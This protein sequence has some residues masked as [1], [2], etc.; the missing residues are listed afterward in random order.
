MPWCVIVSTAAST[1]LAPN[2]V[3]FA[4][5]R[6]AG[7][8]T[9]Q[10]M[11][12]RRCPLAYLASHAMVSECVCWL[13]RPCRLR[14]AEAHLHGSFLLSQLLLLPLLLLRGGRL[15]LWRGAC[16]QF[17]GVGCGV[18][19][20]ACLGPP[21]FVLSYRPLQARSFTLGENCREIVTRFC[22]RVSISSRDL[23]P[24]GVFFCMLQRQGPWPR[25]PSGSG[26]L[27]F[28]PCCGYLGLFPR[29]PTCTVL[30]GLFVNLASWPP[31][32]AK[33]SA[34]SPHPAA[35][36]LSLQFPAPP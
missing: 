16:P 32:L 33:V 22:F 11:D 21:L 3:D 13:R 1:S 35:L 7:S 10:G 30:R 15:P 27:R 18:R 29:C 34:Q 17:W 20:R 36:S 5:P 9:N 2:P 12:A 28:A 8:H 23:S 24:H 25:W 19:V 31:F 26:P 14:A 4:A 6:A